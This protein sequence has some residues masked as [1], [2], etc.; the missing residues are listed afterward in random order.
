MTCEQSGSEPPTERRVV[1]LPRPTASTLLISEPSFGAASGN[2]SH[3]FTRAPPE[4][5]Q[6]QPE[7]LGGT[8]ANPRNLSGLG[9]RGPRHKPPC[10]SD[11]V[12]PSQ[13]QDVDAR[14]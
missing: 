9:D 12:P 13:R 3:R 11:R 8:L 10:R 5:S 6:H 1:R 2:T 7:V 4:P 14:R